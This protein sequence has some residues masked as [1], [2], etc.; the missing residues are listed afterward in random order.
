M[1]KDFVSSDRRNEVT[2]CFSRKNSSLRHKKKDWNAYPSNKNYQLFL[3]HHKNVGWYR[4]IYAMK[5][6][7]VFISLLQCLQ[8]FHYVWLQL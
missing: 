7:R 5:Q 6:T 3:L 8:W 2:Y 4:V 1:Q